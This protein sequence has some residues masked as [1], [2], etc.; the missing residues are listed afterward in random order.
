MSGIKLAILDLYDN[1]PN[2]GLKNIREIIDQFDCIGRVDLF[3]V[4]AK[5]EVPSLDYDIYISTGGPGSPLDGD[6]H[7][8]VQYFDWMQ[9]VWDWNQLE[10]NRRKYVFFICHSFQMACHYFK[11]G[12]ILPRQSPSF[13]IYPVRMTDLGVSDPLFNGLNNPFYAADFRSWQVVQPNVEHI[14]TMGFKILALEK[15]RPHVPLER[16][17]MA[18]RFSD[19]IVGVQFHPEADPDGMRTHFLNPKRRELIKKEHSARKYLNMMDH[20]FDSDNI[21][22]THAIVLPHFLHKTIKNIQKELTYD[23]C[24]SQGV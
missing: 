15:V 6:G 13:G 23:P 24:N 7:W 16:A 17:I 3:D 4:R 19:E 14:E 11:V 12:S 1:T 20:L 8:E 2:L 21:E 10:G 22:L 18:V 9:S 5:A